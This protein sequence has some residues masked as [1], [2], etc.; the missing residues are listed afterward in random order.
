MGPMPVLAVESACLCYPAGKRIGPL[1][2][3]IG[4]GERV[5]LTGESGCGKTTWMEYLVGARGSDVSLETGTCETPRG[6]IGFIPQDPL[7]SLSPYL[8]IGEQMAHTVGSRPAVLEWLSRVG[9][10]GERFAKSRPHQLSGGERQRVLIAL[11]AANHPEIIIADE[12]VA[13]LDEA[14]QAGVLS[15]LDQV[16][17]QTGAALLIAS[18]QES[19]FDQLRCSRVHRMTEPVSGDWTVPSREGS[20]C[21]LVRVSQLRKTFWHR[22][23]LL[24]RAGRHRALNGVTL[25]ISAGETVA[26]LGPSGSGKSTLARCLAARESWDDGE[27]SFASGRRAQLV[28]QEP[29]ASLNPRQLVADAMREATAEPPG[30]LLEAMELSAAL[31]SRTNAALSEGQRGRVG[32]ARAMAA[33]GKGLLVLDETFSS[34]DEATAR[35]VV[36]AIATRQHRTGLGCLL[37]TH[38]R[39][40]ANRMAHRQV[41]MQAGRIEA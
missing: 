1:T 34:L 23:W 40:L 33:A 37:I 29:S 21:E 35:S 7:A 38:D 26:L 15:L 4:P 6:R 5:G 32:I 28:A 12:P 2:L 24:Q 22:N 16:L 19:V 39:Q 25:S 17:T 8:S 41:H 18:H 9:L 30:E 10:G 13:N 27:I 31:L 36:R 14:T 20:G 3:T 11:A